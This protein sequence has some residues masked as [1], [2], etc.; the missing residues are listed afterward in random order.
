MRW[1]T[2]KTK[3]GEVAYRR[4]FALWPVELSDGHTVWLERY[5]AKEIWRECPYNGFYGWVTE[6][7]SVVHP[8]KPDTG[9]YSAKYNSRVSRD[10]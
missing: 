1:K 8:A 5:W 4:Y 10:F 2:D 3:N 9:S 7:T 6:Y